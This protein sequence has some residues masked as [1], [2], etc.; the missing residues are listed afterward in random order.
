MPPAER[1]AA[2]LQAVKP[3][4]AEL[5]ASITTRQ[6]AEIA[7]VSEG[8]I[9]NAFD[10]KDDLIDA[11]VESTLDTTAL[12]AAL[13][14]ID[15]DQPFEARLVEATT[16]MQRRMVEIWRLFAVIGGRVHRNRDRLQV[17]PGLIAIFESAPEQVRLPP[18]DAARVLGAITMALSYPLLGA[19][20][21]SPSEI[22]EQFLHG[23]ARG[24]RR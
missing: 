8:T 22:V 18:A 9:F 2:I 1:R 23:A 5:G 24:G 11:V 21:A 6:L 4:L 13:A 14:A 16:H 7:G 17:S 20:P 12:E 10:D 3:A 15:P 19:R